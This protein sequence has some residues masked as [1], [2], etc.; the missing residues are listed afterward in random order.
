MIVLINNCV[1]DLIDGMKKKRKLQRARMPDGFVLVQTK[2][3]RHL[4]AALK[5]MAAHK[6]QSLQMYLNN[7]FKDFLDLE[8]ENLGNSALL[9]A[10]RDKLTKV[11]YL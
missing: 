2:L 10:I 8:A 9:M 5:M 3:D 4:L 11:R 1:N 7:F 6:E